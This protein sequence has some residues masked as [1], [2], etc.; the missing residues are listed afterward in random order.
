MVNLRQQKK[1]LKKAEKKL[2]D[3]MPVI[4]TRRAK[5]AA[6]RKAGANVVAG[7]AAGVAIG[8]AVGLLFAPKSGKATRK[9]IKDTAE[10]AT[11]VVKQKAEETAET[12]KET[13]EKVVSKVKQKVNEIKH[14]E[15]AFMDEAKKDHVDKK[16]EETE[17]VSA[18]E[19]TKK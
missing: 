4:T 11:K 9:D 7:V 17:T 15:A 8:A 5:K 14:E 6:D 10:K 18:E 13:K 16:P 1:N 3:V 12:V 19:T 2:A